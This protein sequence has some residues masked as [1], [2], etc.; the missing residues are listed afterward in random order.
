MCV[1]VFFTIMCR[2]LFVLF[3]LRMC[4]PP[5]FWLGR[6]VLRK[7]NISIIFFIVFDF[8]CI[9][10]AVNYLLGCHILSP[11]F[12]SLFS[13][14]FFR[15]HFVCVFFVS[16]QFI[17]FV[18]IHSTASASIAIIKQLKLNSYYFFEYSWIWEKSM[19]LSSAG[20]TL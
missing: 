2:W 7:L 18:R 9:N 15:F 13:F 4:P 3:L 5:H 11:S 12:F 14:L 19:G 1:C 8:C 6:L 16:I 10:Y 17:S 20:E